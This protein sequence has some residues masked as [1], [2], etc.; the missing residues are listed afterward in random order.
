MADSKELQNQLQINEQINKV[1]AAR[2][3][4]MQQMQKQLSSQ[5][6]M[7]LELCKAL[8]CEDVDGIRE[9]V[10]S[11]NAAMQDAAD[12]AGEMGS[13]QQK[14]GQEA[15][16]GLEGAREKSG[17]LLD[18]LSSVKAGAIAGGAGF[19]KAFSG[20]GGLMKM[21]GGGIMGV[22]GNLASVGKSIL[23]IPFQMFSGLV[24]MAT[25]GGG[26]TDALREAMNE[27]RGEMGSLAT[28][29]GKA[30]MN[31]FKQLKSSTGALAQSG[32]SMRK[33]FGSG[34]EGLAQMLKDISE[35]A[36]EAGAA[37]PMLKEQLEKAGDAAVMMNKGLGLSNKAL[38]EVMRSAHNTGKSARDEMIEMGSMAIQMG[39]KFG[40]S[41]KTIGKNMS[42][43]I[44]SVEDFGN[45]SKKQL[46]ATAT[47]MAKL[48][49][50]AKDLQG[51]IAK[52]DD[53]ESAAEGVS[54]LNQAFG[55]Q[56]DTMEMMNAQNPA[57][58]ID[59]MRDAFH[60]AGKSVEDMTRAEKKLMA[61]QMGLS[62]SAME[63]ALAT[64]NMGVSYED[65]EE[66]AEESE[67]NKM[68]EKEVMLELADAVKQLTQGG[69]GGVSGFF[70]AFAKGF[71]RGFTRVKGFKELMRAIRKSLRIVEIAGGKFGDMVGK[72]FDQLGLFKSLKKFFDP[73]VFGKFFKNALGYFQKFFDAI[74]GK[75]EYSAAQL[76]EDL[77]NEFMGTFGKAGAE[78]ASGLKTFFIKMIEIAGEVLASA[79]PYLVTKLAEII[80][81]IA[82]FI[83]NPKPAMDAVGGA[84]DGIGGAF[85]EAFGKIYKALK[86]AL[87][88]LGAALKNLFNNLYEL[89]KPFLDKIFM[90]LM[91]S[92]IT[93]GVITGLLVAGAQKGIMV[94]VGFF[95]KKLGFMM[96]AASKVEMAKA[97]TGV[98]TGNAGFFATLNSTI[99]AIVAIPLPMIGKAALVLGAL[100]LMFAVGMVAFAAAIYVAAKILAPIPFADVG[101]ALLSTLVSLYAT[102]QV[103]MVAQII[104][105]PMVMKAILPLLAAAILF[106]VGMVAYALGIKAASMILKKV[107]LLEFAGMMVMVIAAMAA[108]VLFVAAGIAMAAI[109][110][111]AVLGM[112]IIG[113]LAAAVLFTVGMVAF[114][115]GI[116]A[117][118]AVLSKV[119][120]YKDT[121]LDALT[122][123]VSLVTGLGLMI[124]LAAIFA[125][126]GIFVVPL[127]LG[128]G[129]AAGFFFSI[130]PFV[131]KMVGAISAMPMDDPKKIAQKV[132]IVA[133]LGAAMQAIAAVG[134]DAGKMA[135]AAEKMK[136]GG[137]EIMF[138]NISDLISKVSDTLITLIAMIVVL[139]ANLTPGQAK[140]V[141]I[142]AGAIGSIA[143][144]AGAI[145]SPLDAVSKMSEGMF[146]PSVQEVMGAVADGLVKIMEKIRTALP[147]LIKQ[148]V[149]IAT[150]ITEDPKTLKP[151][152]EIVSGALGAVA[153]FASAIE[154]VAALMPEEG[155]FLGM[156]GKSVAERM[157]EMTDTIKGVV[158][159]VEK[160]MGPLVEKITSI[161]IKN[162]EKALK[163]VQVIDKAM[164]ALASFSGTVKK[165]VDAGITDMSAEFSYIARGFV[166]LV[167]PK[168]SSY[169]LVDIFLALGGFQPDEGALN[170][171]PLAQKAMDGMLAF[172]TSAKQT[173]D[174]MAKMGTPL[175]DVVSAMVDE[176]EYALTALN[177]IG[178]LN[179]EV[180]LQNFAQAIGTGSGEFTISNEPININMSVKVV[181]NAGQ[182]ARVLVDKSS[183]T[184]AGGPTLATAE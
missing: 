67:A 14:A 114:G 152:M 21:V 169:N 38:A 115:A 147:S 98:A 127:V 18:S 118:V 56:L 111:P 136:P 166:N 90:T 122:A 49:L 80:Q 10:E 165:M 104:Q 124:G 184:A 121:M 51:V 33:V 116:L 176:A 135:L 32:L 70:D 53:F 42:T 88:K 148:I 132:E 82:D 143:N 44:E 69:G 101:K 64:E 63:N 123:I 62:V 37:F 173:S 29:E 31:S 153:N 154:S 175:G 150:G 19:M 97:A 126:I 157:G 87:P 155:G 142:L 59:M 8:D 182:V 2:S 55:I 79:L 54:Q 75:G 161:P 180:A 30:V 52:F 162:P 16:E 83:S 167:D 134:L 130:M 172:M 20:V 120:N 58:R 183:M 86:P 140:N 117:S 146:G 109:A 164:S 119:A 103:I 23:A 6:Q 91:I 71:K 125:S 96:S 170:S 5:T 168:Y 129:I 81:G 12:K 174:T 89:V 178:D 11:L 110:T 131:K 48:G 112:I 72:L 141:E 34:R 46:T 39:D 13:A 171:F 22:V 60:A 9:R 7:A 24:G 27:L 40:V 28:G 36:K 66:A 133:K 139:G 179:A 61:E 105:P 138:K 177:S 45:M 137:M 95:A 65:M 35:I 43:L 163:Q 159:A 41:A 73:E 156:G 85:S 77:T 158:D 78:G 181:M 107:G 160:Q 113:L 68:S 50:E 92:S 15:A 144:L 76:L 106:S 94:A 108:T 1:L 99:T 25:A 93:K 4:Q 17:G 151:K 128:F 74:T 149:K 102:Q 3:A 26:G 47:Y 145:M 57:E 84:V 100:A